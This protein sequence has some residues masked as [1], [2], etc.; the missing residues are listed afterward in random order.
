MAGTGHIEKAYSLAAESYAAWGVDT[1]AAVE[2]LSQIAI[3]LHC[4]QGDDVGG[5]ETP[6]AT[7]AGGGIQAT[8]N[9]PGK[10]RTPDELRADIEKALSLIPGRH[11]LNLHAIYAETGD[12]KVQRN[13]LAAE[14]FASWIDWAK[15]NVAGLDFNG[16]FF[17]HPKADS[18]FTLSSRDEGV[19][20]FW[21]EHGIACRKIAEQMGL[22]MGSPCVTNVWV[23][24][25]SKDIPIDRKGPREILKKSLDEIF[26]EP[27][28]PKFNLDA[29]ECK[30][31][32]I[33]SESYVV[34]SHEFYMGYALEN[35]K[36]LCLDAGHFHPTEV[37]SDKI[38]SVLTYTD[39]IL[40]HVSRGVRWDS[41]HV[42]ILSDELCA[43][44]QELVRGGYLGRV[45]IGLD[46]FD[47]SINRIAAWTIGTRC[48]IKALL[49]AMLEPTQTLRELETSGDLTG[50]LAMLEET[51]TLPL[52]AVWDYYCL[53]NNVP[54]G[55]AWIDEVR[56]YE[57][58]TL[59][60]RA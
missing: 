25:G 41:D 31:F 39:E 22:A 23:P 33:G 60:S 44:A 13:E 17:S 16:S 18:G 6:D 24:D 45:H 12:K 43:I 7:L 8:G 2:K 36:L 48:M 15:V 46:F 34:G 56:N 49:L 55:P 40:L 30:L 53:K 20:K 59:A 52:G 32:G 51:K 54:A 26:A 29:V 47:A 57:K 35:K 58:A 1:E 42:V 28:D 14:H 37:I 3:S 10:A 5:F 9:Y 27:I 11:R 38:S 19:R 50:R 21:V 4:W